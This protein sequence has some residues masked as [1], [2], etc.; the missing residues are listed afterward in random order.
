MHASV[1]P[2][3][4]PGLAPA[5]IGV[6]ACAKAR[7]VCWSAPRGGHPAAGIS[8]PRHVSAH[9]FIREHA[10][11]A[12]GTAAIDSD[13]GPDIEC[14]FFGEGGPGFCDVTCPVPKTD[15]FRAGGCRSRKLM[16]FAWSEMVFTQPRVANGRCGNEV[17]VLYA[18]RTRTRRTRSPMK[19]LVSTLSTAIAVTVSGSCRMADRGA[20]TTRAT[21][22][23]A[24]A[25]VR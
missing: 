7:V 11:N 13:R 25:A 21:R 15:F 18:Q 17:A 24:T 4:K 16:A 3:H 2:R 19:L 23:A 12:V 20:C 1:H 6:I 10:L 9:A 14:K 5:L 8:A 22:A